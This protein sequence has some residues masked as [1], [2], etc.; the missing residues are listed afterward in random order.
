V[1][2]EA[3]EDFQDGLFLVELAPI[4]DPAPVPLA[5]AQVFVVRDVGNR[6]VLDALKDFLRHKTLLLILDNFEQV[7]AAA[8]IV[9]DLLAATPRHRALVKRQC[10]VDV[11]IGHASVA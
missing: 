8:P 9:A 6:P 7:V 1:A 2:A 4:T 3:L 10:P 5:V 11:S